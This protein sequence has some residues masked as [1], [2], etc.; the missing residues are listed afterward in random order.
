MSYSLVPS[1]R[2]LWALSW[3]SGR[4]VFTRSGV[5]RVV[6]HV[7]L[8]GLATCGAVWSPAN[9]LHH[10]LVASLMQD[11]CA[12]PR[13][14]AIEEMRELKTF[15]ACCPRLGEL[16]WLGCSSRTNHA[17]WPAGGRTGTAE[18][19][20]S[21]QL[22]VPRRPSLLLIVEYATKQKQKKRGGG[23]GGKHVSIASTGP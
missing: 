18:E 10:H 1:S 13:T 9:D 7:Y 8:A 11:T 3:E 21:L 12:I 14:Q 22:A 23:C 20:G 2:A 15:V 6:R 16:W 17:D 4:G 19:P 5:S